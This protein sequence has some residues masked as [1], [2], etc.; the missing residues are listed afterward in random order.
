MTA[1]QVPGHGSQL[2]GYVVPAG[3]PPTVS[4]L[5]RFLAGRL[6]DYM[7][8]SAFVMLPALPLTSSGKLDPRALP[9]PGSLRPLLDA[10][11]APPGTSLQ[12][13]LADLVGMVLGVSPVGAGD[14][15]FEL[16]GD[17]IR[18]VEL[19]TLADRGSASRYRSMRCS[20]RGPSPRWPGTPSP[21]AMRTRQ[22]W[23]ARRG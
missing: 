13:S 2:V 11:F 3:D 14:D 12:Q 22:G 4:S 20:R 7:I 6:P 10:P 1:R 16:G 19:V 9:A 18:A 15:F 23:R 17:S 21:L 5:R 8:P